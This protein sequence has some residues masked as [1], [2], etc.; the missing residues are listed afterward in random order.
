MTQEP[1]AE[2]ELLQVF[3]SQGHLGASVVK[4]KLEAAGIPALLSYESVG[5]V[6]GLTA[7]G[8]GEVRVLVPQQYAHDALELIQEQDPPTVRPPQDELDEIQDPE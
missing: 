6:I 7:D 4:A 5:R 2:L 3:A 8:L 1:S